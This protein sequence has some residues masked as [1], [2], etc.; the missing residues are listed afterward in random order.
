MENSE[1]NSDK[2]AKIA[3]LRE[4]RRR[5]ILENSENRLGKIAGR[6][7]QENKTPENDL[8]AGS[9]MYPDPELEPEPNFV[10]GHFSGVYGSHPDNED[11]IHM[12][13]SMRNVNNGFTPGNQGFR[14]EKPSP[15]GL[16]QRFLRTK[17]HIVLISIAV[18]MI[19]ATG[20]EHIVSGNVF[21]ALLLWELAEVL[22]L[23][24]YQTRSSFAVILYLIGRIPEEY[25]SSA[26]K[27][28][29][30]INKVLQDVAVFTFFF[31]LTH[32]SWHKFILGSDLKTLLNQEYFERL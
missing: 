17:I 26:I 3:A 4:A 25:T 18:Y 5:K 28:F 2:Q 8:A 9:E 15:P 16:I 14:Q 27:I 20:N 13:N 29:E 1:Q 31:V 7:Q 10:P 32:L 6:P 24:T 21:L 19:F 23:R 11:I 30:T 12:L 22:I